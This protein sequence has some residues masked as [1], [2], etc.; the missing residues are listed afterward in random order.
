VLLE[1]EGR[2]EGVVLSNSQV[3]LDGCSQE[4]S[5]VASLR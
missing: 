1:R 5:R 4:A 3:Y 2:M